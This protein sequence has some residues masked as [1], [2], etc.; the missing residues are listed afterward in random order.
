MN[1]NE[2]I[3]MFIK[4]RPLKLPDDY[5]QLATLCS[6]AYL[7]TDNGSTNEPIPFVGVLS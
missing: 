6:A 3:A 7:R 1:E 5:A 4:L 2:V